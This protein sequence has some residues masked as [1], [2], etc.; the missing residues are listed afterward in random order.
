MVFSS[1]L[2]PTRRN[3]S[4]V[5]FLDSSGNAKVKGISTAAALLKKIIHK[6][7]TGSAI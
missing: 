2:L 7:T 6:A 4:R 1:Y 3:A 5:S